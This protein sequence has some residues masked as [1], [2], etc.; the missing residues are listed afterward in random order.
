MYKLVAIDLDGTLLNSGKR[1]SDE[2]KNT[3][4]LAM[5]KGVKIVVCS[6]RI[7]SGARIFALEIGTNGP[8]IACNGAIIKDLETEELLYTSTLDMEDSCKIIDICRREDIYFHAYIG[9]T[10]Y[11][12]KLDYSSLFY[13]ERNQEL[14]EEDRIDIQ[15]VESMKKL[16]SEIPTPVAKFVVICKD[17]EKLLR[18]RKLVERIEGV[19]VVSSGQDNFEVVN[20]GVGKGAAL[21]FLAERLGIRREETM[22]I[23]DNEN[24]ISMLEYAGLSIVM[25][26]GEPFVKELADFIT[27]SNNENGV[28][29]AIRKFIL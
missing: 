14:P 10:M 27:V 16:L 6:G 2:N 12:E 7:F 24:D 18:I 21:K 19:T 17:N 1:I 22:A 4:R 23:G 13:W 26:N 8:L 15:I 11:T 25:E 3:L 20:A 9:D 29:Y 28:A 5:E